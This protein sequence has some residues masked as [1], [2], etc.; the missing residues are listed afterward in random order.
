MSSTGLEVFDKTIQTTNIWL[1]EIMEKI[2]PDRHV[3]WRVLR[4]VLHGLRDRLPIELTAHLSAELPL[5]VRGVYYDQW[6]PSRE[7]LKL[8]TREEFL[9]RVAEE[10]KGNR[11]VNV[12]QAAQVVFQVIDH[13]IEAGQVKK[14]RDA[15]PE[16]VR[17][18]WP[19]G[20]GRQANTQSAA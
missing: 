17:E 15:L 8:R 4:A 3:A 12:L 14:V 7:P 20:A 13:H 19:A 5:L 11:H 16:S 10:L 6:K 1:D 9:E 18:L 2:G